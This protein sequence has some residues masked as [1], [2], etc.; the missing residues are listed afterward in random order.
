MK[1][2]RAIVLQNVE[3]NFAAFKEAELAKTKGE[4]FDDAYKINFMED[5]LAY[6]EN[7]EF[8]NKMYAF[9][10]RDKDHILDNLYKHYMKYWDNTI[11]GE[12]EISVFVRDYYETHS[13]RGSEM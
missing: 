11:S 2:N 3:D 1:K 4:I 8:D 13:E 9:F 6:F 7:N 10:A 5:V 12:D